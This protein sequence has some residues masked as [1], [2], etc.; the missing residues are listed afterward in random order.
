MVR[1]RVGYAGGK[2]RNPTY[3]SLGDHTETLQ[4]DYDPAQISYE[5]LLGVFWMAHN[6]TRRSWSQ[7]YKAAIFYHN[8]AQQQMALA[9]QTQQAVQHHAPITT[10]II[11]A[12]EFYLAEDYHQKYMLSYSVE[13]LDEF[14]AIYPNHR[15]LVNSTAAA[16]VNGYVSGYGDMAQ[17]Q[18]ELDRLGLSPKGRQRL[19]EMA[20]RYQR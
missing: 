20:R 6:P 16:R 1:T 17:L 3:H 14:R 13:L 19:L 15:D 9:S 12:S 5:E 10:E 7:Q 4:L 8:Q 18:Q 2:K 11:P